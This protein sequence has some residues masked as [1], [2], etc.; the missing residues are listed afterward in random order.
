MQE[1]NIGYVLLGLGVISMFIAVGVVI[2]TFTG[3]MSPVSV[4]NIAA[5]TLDTSSFV[6][7][8]LGGGQKIEIIP[9]TAFNKLLNLGVEFLLMTFI[10][11]FGFKLADL[12]VKLVRPVRAH[13]KD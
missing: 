3:N 9:T 10:L 1:K 13:V 7:K 8:L 11:S 12:G 2:L 5:P 4:F 6:P